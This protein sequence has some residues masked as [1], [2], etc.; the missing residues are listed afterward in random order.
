MNKHVVLAA[1]AVTAVQEHQEQVLA[2]EHWVSQ[3][4]SET[5]LVTE[6]EKYLIGLWA[7]K[8]NDAMSIWREEIMQDIAKMCR[9][10]KYRYNCPFIYA[11]N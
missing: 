7:P 2:A 3:K 4:L 10:S 8:H 5:S 6:V 11:N 9:W 1:W